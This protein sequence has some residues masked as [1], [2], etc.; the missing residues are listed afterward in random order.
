ME[1]RV[2]LS[3]Q[4]VRRSA[5]VFVLNRLLLLML[6]LVSRPLLLGPPLFLTASVG[7][8]DGGESPT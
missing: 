6:V 1:P 3:F 2:L 7:D 4:V 8:E 5:F